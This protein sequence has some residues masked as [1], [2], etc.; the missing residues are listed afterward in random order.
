MPESPKRSPAPAGLRC[1]QT[2]RETSMEIDMPIKGLLLAE[3]RGSRLFFASLLEA[4]LATANSRHACR[5]PTSGRHFL[6]LVEHVG[7]IRAALADAP[8]GPGAICPPE[9]PALA[10]GSAVDASTRPDPAPE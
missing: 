8:A 10:R 4:S 9:R 3:T 5:P 6:D 7:G 1:G 2:R